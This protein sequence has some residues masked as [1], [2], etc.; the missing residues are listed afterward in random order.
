MAAQI[1]IGISGWRYAPWRGVFYPVGLTQ[2]KE[3]RF[4]SRALSTIEINGS[5][6]SLQR[7]QS[8]AN[9]YAETG[10]D[11]IFSVKG[12]RYITHILRLKDIEKAMANFLASGIFE[13][14][15][16]LGPI[17]WQF[18]AN[19]RFDPERFEAFLR[20]LPQDTQAA[21]AQAM[22][23]EERME[24]RCCLH[25][26]ANRPLRHAVEIRHESF[27][28][29]EFIELLRR[30]NVALVVADTAGKWLYREDITADFVYI[31]LHGHEQLYTSRYHDEI[32]QEWASRIQAW[33]QGRQ[34]DNAQ[35]ID[36]HHEPPARDYRDVYCY[37]DND[38][39]VHAPFDADRL[40]VQLGLRPALGSWDLSLIG[41][42]AKPA[43]KP[44]S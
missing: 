24:G 8:Y 36:P 9:W 37:F 18:P 3:L 35:L 34:P 20:L 1:R 39:N 4:A 41:E 19:L 2:N 14:K 22:K 32:L 33:A 12:P 13:L 16:K 23:C 26:D 31:R 10:E 21:Q 43:R 11:F 28:T 25:I 44:K 6:Y 5:F 30:Y 17:L 15:E 27:I 29:P 7:P 38:A 40:T 42:A